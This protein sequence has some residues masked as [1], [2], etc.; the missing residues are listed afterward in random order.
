M[1]FNNDD[2]KQY[3]FKVSF[4]ISKYITKGLKT[5]VCT[6][7]FITH[8]LTTALIGNNSSTY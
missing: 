4:D 5:D 2:I 1:A 8:L 6:R 3:D 7:M